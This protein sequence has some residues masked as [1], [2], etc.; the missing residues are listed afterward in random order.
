MEDK[1]GVQESSM[2]GDVNHNRAGNWL[3][4]RRL[5]AALSEVGVGVG[6]EL[7]PE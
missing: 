3:D 4:G 6:V 5:V 2:T 7:F 1:A